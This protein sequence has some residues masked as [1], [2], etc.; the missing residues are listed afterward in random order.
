MRLTRQQKEE[1]VRDGY[2]VLPG[3]VPRARM[4]EAIAAVDHAYN[5]QQ[6]SIRLNTEESLP[7]F[8]NRLQQSD[9]VTNLVWKTPLLLA[10]EDLY[11]NGNVTILGN[12]GQVAFRP[13]QKRF[14]DKG[15]GLTQKL[16]NNFW[17]VDDGPGGKYVNGPA[18][19]TTLLGIALSPG[20]DVDENRGQLNV[21]PGLLAIS[22]CSPSTTDTISIADMCFNRCLAL[23]LTW[24]HQHHIQSLIRFFVGG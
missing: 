22:I 8:Y 18:S 14:V 15:F 5:T 20:Q 11:G 17:H 19:F 12:A 2:I 1:F 13:I 23:A 4:L 10:L 24:P 16:G 7:A 9:A 21:W 3:V 6:Y